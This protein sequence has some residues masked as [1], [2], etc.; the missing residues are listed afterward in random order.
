M[1]EAVDKRLTGVVSRLERGVA[2]GL[3]VI[4]TD[5]KGHIDKQVQERFALIAGEVRVKIRKI[6]SKV[7]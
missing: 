1:R 7:S 5:V 4:A 2:S 3:A 6:E